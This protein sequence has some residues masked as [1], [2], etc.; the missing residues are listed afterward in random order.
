M[1][2]YSVKQIGRE[3]MVLALGAPVLKFASRA[4]AEFVIAEVSNL[5]L[6]PTLRPPDN[7]PASVG[8]ESVTADFET[9]ADNDQTLSCLSL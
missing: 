3:F 1:S 8:A 2:E 7:L 6:R 4:E 5:S 9:W